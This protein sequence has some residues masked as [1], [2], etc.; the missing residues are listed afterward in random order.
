MESPFG[1]H[2]TKHFAQFHS[3]SEHGFV[4]LT[5]LIPY[6]PKATTFFP[7]GRT[8]AVILG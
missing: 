5:A 8:N 3:L 6:L 2:R 4:K 7:P 1:F